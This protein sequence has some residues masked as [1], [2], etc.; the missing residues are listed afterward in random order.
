LFS[1]SRFVVVDPVRK[2]LNFCQKTKV[3]IL[4]VVENMG[5]YT[6]SL[7]KLKF[8]SP[9]GQKDC[10]EEILQQLKTSCP[11][12]L[13][14]L[15]VAEIYPPSGGGPKAMAE[16]FNVPYWGV[17]P[18][19]PDLLQACENGK[20]FV[21]ACPDSLAAKALKD[22]CKKITTILPVEEVN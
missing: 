2:E 8:M 17:L 3:P 6:T 16:R 18:M 1:H 21:D 9:D 22:F 14:S 4:G 10:T 5:N 15:V 19:D 20:P 13:E 7:N 12:V 11:Q